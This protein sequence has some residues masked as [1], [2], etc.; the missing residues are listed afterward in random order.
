MVEEPMLSCWNLLKSPKSRQKSSGNE[1]FALQMAQSMQEPGTI[2]FKEGIDIRRY[3]F[4]SCTD[5]G[6][7]SLFAL[8]NGLWIGLYALTALTILLTFFP[9]SQAVLSLLL[10]CPALLL[11]F[12]IFENASCHRRG[13]LSILIKVK[14]NFI[15]S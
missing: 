7:Y 14:S 9:F 1:D 8:S 6:W 2:C 3:D 10:K 5:Y 4:A 15:S 13:R 12:L 11:E